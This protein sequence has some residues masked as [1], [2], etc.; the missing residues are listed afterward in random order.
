MKEKRKDNP[1]DLG[2][3]VNVLVGTFVL[4]TIAEQL[5]EKKEI[6]PKRVLFWLNYHK[7]ELFKHKRIDFVEIR[8]AVLDLLEL[9]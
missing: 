1:V 8:N 2:S 4:A 9:D 7:D 6:F 5:F 3:L